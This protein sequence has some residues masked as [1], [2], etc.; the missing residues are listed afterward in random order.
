[1]EQPTP[2]NQTY[3][4]ID[5]TNPQIHFKWSAPLRAYKKRKAGILRF[6]VA[7]SLVLSALVVLFGDKILVL[8]IW[9]V[10]FLF[11]ILT[12]TPPPIIENKITKFGI[13]T[14]GNTIRWDFL[15]HFY[16]MKKFDYTVMVVVSVAP[17]FY[18]LYLVLPN[19][20]AKP[21]IIKILSEHLVYQEHPRKTLTDKLIEGFSKLMPDYGEEE[22]EKKSTMREVRL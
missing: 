17:Y 18:H 20:E 7:L 13:E 22:T 12:I 19:E 1:M 11:Y 8:P 4:P 15:S 3:T 5:T 9:A 21:K 2:K 10:M 6:Y 14:N 16:F